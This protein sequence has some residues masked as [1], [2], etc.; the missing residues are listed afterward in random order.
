MTVLIGLL[1]SSLPI[2]LMLAL[3]AF[4]EW[5]DRRR[6]EAIA[7]Q[8]AITDAIHRHLG[9]VVAPTVEPS[10]TGPWR[11]AIAT[12]FGRPDVIAAVVEIAHHAARAFERRAAL[13]VRPME[14]VLTP[15]EDSRMMDEYTA[16]IL[17]EDRLRE[18]RAEAERFALLETIPR[19]PV[20]ARFGF[21]LMRLGR[22]LA[23]PTH[24]QPSLT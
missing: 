3:V 4:V 14:I 17:V 24:A 7:R 23:A 19:T 1:I 10:L 22:W 2:A 8:I 15:Q 6:Q 18:F 20:R 11:L 21:A 16:S 12:P 9:A 5:R 13:A